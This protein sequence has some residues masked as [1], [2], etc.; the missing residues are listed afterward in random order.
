MLDSGERLDVVS[1]AFAGCS[2]RIGADRTPAR[3]STVDSEHPMDRLLRKHI[4]DVHGSDIHSVS[5]SVLSEEELQQVGGYRA[6]WD[7][8]K[9]ALAIQER[10]RYPDVGVSVDRRAFE[11]TTH[12]YRNDYI[13]SLVCFTCARVCL[14]T[15]GVRSAIEYHT[16]SLFCNITPS[17]L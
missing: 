3:S 4:L 12:V 13:R 6:L 10:L 2:H 7:I 11:Y 16:G 14:D 8:Y 15:G 5:R 17:H 1:C 9:Q